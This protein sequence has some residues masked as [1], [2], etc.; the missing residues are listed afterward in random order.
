M[1]GS[2]VWARQCDVIRKNGHVFKS[3]SLINSVN[4]SFLLCKIG[5]ISVVGLKEIVFKAVY[6][7]DKWGFHSA[8]CMRWMVLL[9][10]STF[11]P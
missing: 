3:G 9:G 4:L 5:M 6:Q 2:Y 7:I 10:G 8:W 11:F 1:G